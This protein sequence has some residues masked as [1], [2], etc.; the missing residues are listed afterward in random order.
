MVQQQWQSNRGLSHY[1]TRLWKLAV[2]PKHI[3][4]AAPVPEQKLAQEFAHQLSGAGFQITSR[5]L[6]HDFLGDRPDFFHEHER[7]KDHQAA[8]GEF[9]LADVMA[10]DTLIILSK[11]K[12]STGGYHVELGCFLG[13]G[14]DNI[15]VVGGRPNVFFWTR[16]VRYS[17]STEGLIEWLLD[18][19]HGENMPKEEG[20]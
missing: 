13:A 12:S 2:K 7:W 19:G 8:W 6:G 3:Y 1:D 10:A 15:I 5:W 4:V 17:P 20:R 18:E 16:R 14:R 9:D 11:E